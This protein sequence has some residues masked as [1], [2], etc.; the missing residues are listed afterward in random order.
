MKWGSRYDWSHGTKQNERNQ[1]SLGC[2]SSQLI[3][4]SILINDNTKNYQD[5][6][7]FLSALFTLCDLTRKFWVRVIAD[8]NSYVD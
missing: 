2:S 8:T 7:T 3:H 6:D 4:L 1:S 5:F